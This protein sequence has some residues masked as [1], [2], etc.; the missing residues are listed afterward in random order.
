MRTEMER[1]NG[2]GGKLDQRVGSS[3]GGVIASEREREPNQER[4]GG[5]C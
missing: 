1:H 4:E 2:R 3:S 5:R